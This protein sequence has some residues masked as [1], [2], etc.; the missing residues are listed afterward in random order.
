MDPKRN[1]LTV[2]V[3]YGWST[4]EK[5]P[6]WPPEGYVPLRILRTAHTRRIAPPDRRR[7]FV[8]GLVALAAASAGLWWLAVSLSILRTPGV[9]VLLLDAPSHLRY[10]EL[11]VLGA[12]AA[13]WWRYVPFSSALRR[14]AAAG[15]AAAVLLGFLPLA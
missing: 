2:R 10:G 7:R 8:L 3:S 12:F 13:A 15:A 14:A 11:L 9:H 5:D 4:V 6:A 1:D